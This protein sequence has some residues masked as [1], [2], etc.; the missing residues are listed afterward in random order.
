MREQVRRVVRVLR[1][2]VARPK[3]RRSKTV[4]WTIGVALTLVIASLFPTAH[5]MAISGYSVGSLWTS[6]DIS[7]PFSYPVY[8]DITRYRS[9]VRKALDNLY[10]VYLP[11]TA[12]GEKA[13]KSFRSA[14][15]RMSSLV[16]L[17]RGDTIDE[18]AFADSAKQLGLSKEEWASLYGFAQSSKP[19]RLAQRS[20]A[21]LADE[22]EYL[23]TQIAH[24]E[25]VALLTQGGSAENGVST[26]RL[27]SLRIHPNEEAVLSRDSLLTI[28]AAANRIYAKLEQRLKHDPSLVRPF[29]KLVSLALVPNVAFNAALT[30]ESHNAIVDRVPRTDGI[31]VEGQRIISKGDILTPAMKASLESLSQARLDRGGVVAQ[32]ARFCRHR[33]SCG[34]DRSSSRPVYNVYTPPHL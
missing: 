19:A 2:V 5:T 11:D 21:Q 34:T 33:W 9:D 14:W 32:L 20:D 12:A 30:E 10:P 6:E 25:S 18:A 31:I 8:K 4:R 28:D 23:A 16:V 24:L 15:D 27:F 13:T 17:S 22:G 1:E 29:S 26:S 3:W 7:A